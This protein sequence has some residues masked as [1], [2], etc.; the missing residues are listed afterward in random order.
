VGEEAQEGVVVLADDLDQEVVGLHDLILK[1]IRI[2]GATNPADRVTGSSTTRSSLCVLVR[3]RLRAWRLMA[4]MVVSRGPGRGRPAADV[5]LHHYSAD[6]GENDR[7][8]VTNR[9]P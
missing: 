1:A 3:R 2:P 6:T 7:T 9:R 8:E 5:A 4:V